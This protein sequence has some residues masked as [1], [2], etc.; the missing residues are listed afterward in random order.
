MSVLH[1]IS[2]L[3]EDVEPHDID[4]SNVD[5]IR[6]ALW[7]WHKLATDELYRNDFHA[8]ESGSPETRKHFASLLL[9][10]ITRSRRQM[11]KAKT[12]GTS[13][14][15]V[16]AA[17]ARTD[18]SASLEGLLREAL[19]HA[20]F[21][22]RIMPPPVDEQV[23]HRPMVR[24]KSKTQPVSSGA[25]SLVGEKRP[26]SPSLE[27]V[28][29]F[30]K[31]TPVKTKP[32][33]SASTVFVTPQP[34]VHRHA[35]RSG[36]SSVTNQT[37]PQS[38]RKKI[39]IKFRMVP[40]DMQTRQQLEQCGCNPKVEL[41]LSSTKRVTDVVAHM[42][43]KWSKVRSLLPHDA[44]LHFFPKEASAAPSQSWSAK[45][46]DA[47][48]LDI[49]K[50]SG[51]TK[52]DEYV[53]LVSYQWRSVSDNQQELDSVAE[54]ELSW[55]KEDP[56]MP[57]LDDIFDDQDGMKKLDFDIDGSPL[58]SPEHGNPYSDVLD[59]T[60]ANEVAAL[61]AEGSMQPSKLS[62]SLQEFGE[63]VAFDSRAMSTPKSAMSS[64]NA[65]ALGKDSADQSSATSRLRRRITP[66]LVQ[67]DECNL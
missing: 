25:A 7:C 61:V 28:D 23:I 63:A 8:I 21:P 67:T 32:A 19:E 16:S 43:K 59:L 18:S 3:L 51:K 57:L 17:R 29:A 44:E 49:W 54:K 12:S 64:P 41:K 15:V 31:A 53:V 45:H 37:P 4:L 26:R 48:C 9:Q 6:L 13:T 47:S 5:E 56:S 55:I 46:N 36:A 34:V 62:T 39:Y 22:S 42:M 14:P 65:K 2:D 60:F 50:H 11:L 30:A 20:S 66:M 33:T 27:L 24:R 52:N 38:S 35:S 58:S 1:H 40:R 10:S